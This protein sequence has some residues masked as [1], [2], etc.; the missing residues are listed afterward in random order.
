MT[1]RKSN[2]TKPSM[3]IKYGHQGHLTSSRKTDVVLSGKKKETAKPI[4][5]DGLPACHGENQQFTGTACCGG[6]GRSPRTA[7][8]TDGQTD[9]Q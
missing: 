4:R 2:F 7:Q 5:R 1:L 8:Q 3:N 6:T 9:F